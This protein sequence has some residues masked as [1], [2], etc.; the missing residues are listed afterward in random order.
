MTENQITN[1]AVQKQSF[2][3]KVWKFSK[4]KWGI[5][6]IVVI[7]LLLGYTIFHKKSSPYTFVE[8]RT[9]SITEV[10]SV[11]GNTTPIQSVSLAFENGGTIAWVNS[12]VGQTAYAGQVLAQL[13]VNDL[14]AQL[15]QAQANVDTQQAKLDSIKAGS[16]PEDI[17]SSEASLSK[18]EQDLANMYSGIADSANDSY[19]KGNDAVHTQI[20]T[21]F[22]NPDNA[23]V[24]LT[25]NTLNTQAATN[26]KSERSSMSSLLSGWQK[27]IVT[28]SAQSSAVDLDKVVQDSLTNLGLIRQL[29]L[30][31]S[32]ALDGAT[33]LDATT[34][35]ADKT[36]LTT[37]LTGV[38]TAT[39]NLNTILQ[40]IA[41]Q[42]LVVAQAQAQLDL[43]KAG[44]T[45]SD[46]SAQQAQLEQAQA[47]M[48]S[49]Q[50]KLSNSKIVS[51]ITGLVTQFDAKVGQI[52]SP[53]TPL[54]SVI[55]NGQ[56]EVDAQVPETDIGRVAVGDTVRMTFDAFPG[57][58]FIG[59]LFYIDPG[60]T[61]N[62]GVVDYKIKVAFD[63]AD[64]RMK[65]GLTANLSIETKT[66]QNALVVPQYAVIQNDAGTFVRTLQGG[67]ATDTPVTL[68]I[69]DQ[70]G[71][72]EILSGVTA[73]EQ[74]INVGL[75]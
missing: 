66:N 35:A 50:A 21:L 18:A 62:Q 41:S 39:K 13:N 12:A 40:T 22:S 73:G 1:N 24:Q 65:S 64:P 15:R 54:V 19:A 43:K 38:N 30:D 57:D 10:V 52:A 8:V 70:D 55:S 25:F 48:Q 47:A 59:K 37:A 28:V 20:N 74:L 2:F 7:L 6:T 3:K 53:G 32:A 27:E 16:R 61:I 29:L 58:T 34:L 5:A 26:A 4:T 56:F 68:G 49:V 75:K 60:Q 42:K 69:Q 14:S 36:A 45:A 9:G 17:A 23:S 67:T 72:V 46:V 11:T 51:P 63:T 71:N 33:N 31:V 44:A